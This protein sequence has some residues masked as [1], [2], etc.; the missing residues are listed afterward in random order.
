MNGYESME[1][2]LSVRRVLIPNNNNP[3]TKAPQSKN[4]KFV[5]GI[6]SLPI[7]P[8]H[9]HRDNEKRDVCFEMCECSNN[10]NLRPEFRM[11][12]RVNKSLQSPAQTKQQTNCLFYKRQQLIT[13]KS[14]LLTS[15]ASVCCFK[16]LFSQIS[17]SRLRFRKRTD[18]EGSIL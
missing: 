4:T 9:K 2:V 10:F 16:K 1:L 11:C 6:D 14:L 7:L 8:T 5:N 17:S 15:S 18:E 12:L 13:E 3:L